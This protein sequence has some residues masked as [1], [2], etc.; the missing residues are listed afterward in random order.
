MQH[1]RKNT[2]LL[3]CAAIVSLTALPAWADS[4]S[5]FSASSTS[6][7]SSSTSIEKSSDS[8]SGKERVAQGPYTVIEVAALIGRPE[9][10]RVHLQAVAGN[11]AFFLVLPRL[12]AERGNL[13]AGQMVTA[14]HRPYGVAL[15]SAPSGEPFFLVMDDQWYRELESRPV[16]I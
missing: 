7:G 9:M 14:M 1:I 3:A 10:L 15:A 8:V 5:V 13:V 12:A 11:E 4:S 6:V 2:L 16:V